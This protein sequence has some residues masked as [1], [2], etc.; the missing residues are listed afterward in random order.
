MSP[1][2]E[3]KEQPFPILIW[4]IYFSA[5][6]QGP[7]NEERDG[8]KRGRNRRRNRREL[9]STELCKLKRNGVQHQASG[10][11]RLWGR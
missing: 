2:A 5:Y 3:V 11:G 4:L 6:T 8:G 10:R 7:F 9:G 1:K